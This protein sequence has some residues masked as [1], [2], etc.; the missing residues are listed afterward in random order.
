MITLRH[1]TMN[2]AI[3]TNFMHTSISTFS[4]IT[5]LPLIFIFFHDCKVANS[6]LSRPTISTRSKQG[7]RVARVSLRN[8]NFR[9]G[10]M[11]FRHPSRQLHRSFSLIPTRQA[12]TRL[13]RHATGVAVVI[14][15]SRRTLH[16]VITRNANSSNSQDR[17]QPSALSHLRR[18]RIK[19]DH[20][21]GHRA[22]STR[23]HRTINFSPSTTHRRTT[24]SGVRH[25]PTP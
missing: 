6:P 15:G 4:T 2:T 25:P 24:R 18:H 16:N 1:V 22:R 5:R 12:S 13:A 11:Q 20:N 3:R 8:T 23:P 17:H 10:Q 9:H 14:S 21:K 19:R 7:P